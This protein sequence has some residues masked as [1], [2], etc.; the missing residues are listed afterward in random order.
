MNI[1]L[2][3]SLLIVF[4]M[5]TASF[6]GLGTSEFTGLHSSKVVA[7]LGSQGVFF[8]G[9]A[10]PHSPNDPQSSSGLFSGNVTIY[11]NGSLSTSSAPISVSGHV[12]SLTSNFVGSLNVEANN[13]V[14]NGNNYTITGLSG[15]L[16]VLTVSNVSGV[17]VNDLSVSSSSN[18]SMGVLMF[19][20]SMDQFTDVNI[21]VP[22]LGIDVSNFTSSINISHSRIAVGNGSLIDMGDILTGSYVGADHTPEFAQDSKNISLYRDVIVNNGGLYGVLFNSPN[23]SLKNSSITMKGRSYSGSQ[24]PD[25]FISDQNYTTVSNNFI[26]G[27]NVSLGAGFASS[28]LGVIRLTGDQFNGNNMK[29]V[30]PVYGGIGSLALTSI[31]TNLSMKDNTIYGQNL[32]S[33]SALVGL[34]V[35]NFNVTGNSIKIVNSSSTP[36]IVE[37]DAN[38]TTDSNSI[39]YSANSSLPSNCAVLI[40]SHKLNVDNNSITVKNVSGSSDIM[41]VFSVGSSKIN[42]VSYNTIV[43]RNGSAA[44][45]YFV[46]VNTTISSNSIYLNGSEPNGIVL[47]GS[48]LFVSNNTV[49]INSSLSS[50]GILNLK[51][52]FKIYNSTISGNTVNITGNQGGAIFGMFFQSTLDNLTL[53]NNYLTSDGKGFNGIEIESRSNSNLSISSNTIIDD[54]N[55]TGTFNGLTI[56]C[57]KSAV[58]NGNVILGKGNAGSGVKSNAMS[59]CQLRN[60]IVANNTMEG[61]NTSLL[62]EYAANVTFY[63]NYFQNQYLAL[64]LSSIV[65]ATFYHNDFENFTVAA[66]VNSLFNVSFNA[67]YPVGGNYWANYTGVDQNHGPSQNIPGSDGIGDTP[68]SIN[69]TLKDNYPLMKPWTRPEAVFRSNGLFPGQ[70]WSVTFNGK[71]ITSTQ[72]I[73]SFAILNGTYQNYSY[74]IGTVAG[75]RGGGQSGELDY[76]GSGF[77]EKL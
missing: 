9:L 31:F 44:G 1:K 48:G 77:T 14:L 49:D 25:V 43:G 67:S 47:C 16:P 71:T 6:V 5:A 74:S 18:T 64:N 20:T 21:S 75:Y 22:Y 37:C 54:Y 11:S 55:S 61:V 15:I 28:S 52:P 63:G 19:N 59:L 76:V 73:I 45:I 72:K 13:S 38:T 58:I 24:G 2:T 27:I 33:G 12:Y 51:N 29:I 34:F 8:E 62:M 35:G 40:E 3:V 23:S 17:N 56:S 46:G 41:K 42:S 7:V 10:G 26:Y 36:A 69:A 60:L 4:S 30:S 39:V 32:P 65:F 50:T 66:Q 57:V 53:S 68:Y 70:A